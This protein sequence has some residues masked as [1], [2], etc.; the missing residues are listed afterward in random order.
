MEDPLVSITIKQ[1]VLVRFYCI[2]ALYH[3]NMGPTIE[4]RS[5]ISLLFID[6]RYSPVV[7]S[8]YNSSLYLYL[9]RV[10]V[11]M[12][13]KINNGLVH[14]QEFKYCN[15]SVEE[16]KYSIISVESKIYSY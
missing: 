3:S 4:L 10:Q 13:E 12:R 7:I 15:I 1:A 8:F 5:S 14:F 11:N 9:T 2:T 16:F 6:V